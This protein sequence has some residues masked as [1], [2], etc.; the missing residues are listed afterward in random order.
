M[1][2]IASASASVALRIENGTPWLSFGFTISEITSN[3]E[4]IA[5]E[6]AGGGEDT[7]DC[8]S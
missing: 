8:G 6:A 5:G 3:Q 7:G 2:M 1:A 4:P